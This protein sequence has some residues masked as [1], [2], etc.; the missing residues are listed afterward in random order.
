MRRRSAGP[1]A[2]AEIARASNRLNASRPA[3]SIHQITPATRAYTTNTQPT[4]MKNVPMLAS[5]RA[6]LMSWSMGSSGF[7]AGQS[8]DAMAIVRA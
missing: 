7:E 1:T 3:R 5:L 8:A 4:M 2:L 6:S